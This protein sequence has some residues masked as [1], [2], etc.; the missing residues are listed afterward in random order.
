METKTTIEPEVEI[1]SQ[2]PAPLVLRPQTLFEA[3]VHQHG[4]DIEEAIAAFAR[5]VPAVYRAALSLTGPQ[6]WTLMGTESA[7]L[8]VSG[9]P[10]VAQFIGFSM[11][12]S[13][14]DRHGNPELQRFDHPTEAGIY[15]YRIW[16]HAKSSLL[17]REHSGEF[18]RR[19]DEEFAG[20]R[21]RLS[22]PKEAR[23][24][25][26][27]KEAMKRDAKSMDQDLR[28]AV[29]S[30]AMR[31]AITTLTGMRKVS[32]SDLEQAW[33]GTNKKVA[34][35]VGGAGHGSGA[36]RKA[37]EADADPV[38][39]D[40]ARRVLWLLL[41]EATGQDETGAKA[42]CRKITAYKTKDGKEGAHDGPGKMAGWAIAKAFETWSNVEP[43][44]APTKKRR[45]E[46]TATLAA[47]VSK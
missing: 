20:R 8:G 23:E 21:D 10:L 39:D 37:R 31:D 9:A 11:T 32:L 40:I 16:Y 33:A 25:D 2:E 44:T 46:L 12:Y 29:L 28:R 4:T 7:Y 30:G 24:G 45:D 18:G 5:M 19:N 1:I 26:G 6:D 36:E 34:S 3:A 43:E 41:L 13:P 35:I 17:G 42:L 14:L 38:G 47:K 15:G 22:L 27:F